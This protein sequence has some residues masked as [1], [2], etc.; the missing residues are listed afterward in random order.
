VRANSAVYCTH[1][2]SPRLKQT[3]ITN[4]ERPKRRNLRVPQGVIQ[5]LETWVIVYKLEIGDQAE[6]LAIS[7][8]VLLGAGAAAGLPISQRRIGAAMNTVLY[9]PEITPTTS[10]NANA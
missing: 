9:V 2:Q 6:V 1:P 7:R 5:T 10:A 8:P 4:Y 3:P